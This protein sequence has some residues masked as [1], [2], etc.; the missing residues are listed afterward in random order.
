[1]PDNANAGLARQAIPSA[2]ALVRAGRRRSL[3][4]LV[5]AVAMSVLAACEP[6][7]PDDGPLVDLRFE[8]YTLGNGLEVILR[9]D[10]RVPI[11][12]VN[13]WYHVGPANEARGPDRV[14]A[15]VRA[16]DVPG[17]GHAGADAHF[18]CLEAVGAT[19]VNGT[20]QLRP[21]QLLRDVP[22]NALELALWLESD[23]MGF[24]LDG[25]RPGEAVQ[26]AARSCATSAGRARSRSRRA[27]GRGDVPA[28]VPRGPPVPRRRHRFARRTSRPRSSRDVRDF[29]ARYYVPN[30]ASLAIVGDIDIPATKALIEKYFGTIPRGPDVPKPQVATPQP[31]REQRLT[32]SDQVEL[33]RVHHGLGDP[34]GVRRRQTPRP[35]WRPACSRAARPAGST[36][37]W[38]I[39]P[40]SR[41][42]S[43]PPSSRSATARCSRSGRRRSRGTAPTRL[44]AA[45]GRELDALATDGPTEAEL[46]AVTTR[47][48]AATIFGLEPPAAVASQ[49][50]HYNDYLG[51]P[52]YLDRDLQRYADVDAQ[53]VQR[54]VT[55]ALS[56]DRR[57]VVHTEPGEK[58]LPPDPPAPPT[59]PGPRPPAPA[60]S[61]EP[62]RNT[63]PGLGPAAAMALP[64]AQ[65]FEL[66]NGLP[67]YLVES[68]DLPITVASLVSRWGSAA[69][70]AGRPGLAAFT[71]DMLDEGTQTRDALGIAREIDSLGRL[72]LHRGRRRRQLVSVAALSPRSA[73]RWR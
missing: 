1:M 36:R 44:E 8:K 51:D 65:R 23:R 58:V 50:N 22:S 15:P 69:E 53:D 6:P 5:V 64:G 16:H 37:R 62:W 17:L 33:P 55:D 70:P 26:P 63:V 11:V 32:I 42:T 66:D 54:F 52:G 60:P 34:T 19:D 40:A 31:T 35:T 67:V 61:A 7:P 46:A 47:I 24:L 25:A 30:N 73:G 49:L 28:P 13:V 14:R 18:G 38:C 27:V 59:L 48:R 41:R 10:H 43:R 4:W 39:G 3:V 68:H 71:A 20:H 21:H 56:R 57:L 72:P 29:F 45:I 9:E 12:A 2:S